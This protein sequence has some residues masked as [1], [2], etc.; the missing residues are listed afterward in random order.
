MMMREQDLDCGSHSCR[1]ARVK[2]GMRTNGRCMCIDRLFSTI[3]D[4]R[5]VIEQQAK[6]IADLK[7]RVHVDEWYESLHANGA[8]A[9]DMVRMI[10]KKLKG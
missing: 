3:F 10:L 2:V 1:F 7:E 9:E 5:Q 8:S 4:Q 6:E